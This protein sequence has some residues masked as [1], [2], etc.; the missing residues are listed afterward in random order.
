MVV[1]AGKIVD[2]SKRTVRWYVGDELASTGLGKTSFS[3]STPNI[4]AESVTIRASV[5]DSAD[6]QL[7]AFRDIPLVRPEIVI[8]RA[9]LP[10]LTPLFYSFS[11]TDPSSLS[12]TWYD[13]GDTIS[14]TA[15]NPRNPFEFAQTS[16]KR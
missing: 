9:Q 7:D 1:D 14:A 12:V 16:L 2:L 3:F 5:P 15:R 8:D 13:D 4:G 10:Q 11:I 6:S